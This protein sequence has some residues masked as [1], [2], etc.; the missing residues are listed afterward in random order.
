MSGQAETGGPVTVRTQRRHGALVIQVEGEIDNDTCD[1]VRAE[2]VQRL[3][4]RPKALVLDL[5]DV[6][7]FGSIG[8]SLLIEARHRAE[9]LGVGFA[10]AVDRR[11]AL[12]PLTETGVADLLVLRP[13]AGQ[14]AEAALAAPSVHAAYGPK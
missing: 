11:A 1:E 13:D 14:A 4:E 9:A 8:L 6:V 7:V 10:V 5:N 2:V 3:R 12:R